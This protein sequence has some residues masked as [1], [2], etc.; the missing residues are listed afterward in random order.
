MLQ[1]L[2]VSRIKTELHLT[3]GIVGAR[4]M[5]QRLIAWYYMNWE[6]HIS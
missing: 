6:L 5:Y 2:S 4:Y 3:D 1:S